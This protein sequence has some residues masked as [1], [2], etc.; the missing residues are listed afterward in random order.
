MSL[1]KV[2][3]TRQVPLT[4]GDAPDSPWNSSPANAASPW[5]AICSFKDL[6]N[7]DT[8]LVM[9]SNSPPHLQTGVKPPKGGWKRRFRESQP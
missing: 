1:R 5:L 3:K 9:S 7:A 4:D 6:G 8:R 2:I